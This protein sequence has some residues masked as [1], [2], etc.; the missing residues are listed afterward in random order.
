MKDCSANDAPSSDKVSVKD[1]AKLYQEE[2]EKQLYTPPPPIPI[3]GKSTADAETQLPSPSTVSGYG[4]GMVREG[5]DVTSATHSHSSA[6]GSDDIPD[7]TSVSED[8]R[9]A[10]MTVPTLPS[11][12]LNRNSYV[13]DSANTIGVTD[14]TSDEIYVYSNVTS[15]QEMRKSNSN[16]CDGITLGLESVISEVCK[17]NLLIM[18]QGRVR[19]ASTT[20][21]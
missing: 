20:K 16:G 12:R 5:L 9:R 17:D 15:M 21:C 10:S 19:G 11:R 13:T 18:T 3:P 8:R 6:H 2:R 14:A 1:M 4:T 7:V